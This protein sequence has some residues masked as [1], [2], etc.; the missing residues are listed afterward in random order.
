MCS[1][2]YVAYVH[3]QKHSQHLNC[4]SV[5]TETSPARLFDGHSIESSSSEASQSEGNNIGI[6]NY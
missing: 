2:V 6:N 5:V 3:A 4:Y 1:H